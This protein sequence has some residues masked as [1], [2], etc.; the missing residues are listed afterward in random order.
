[1]LRIL[2]IFRIHQP[3]K[4]LI[5]IRII[6]MNISL[7]FSDFL[8]KKRIFI[9][10]FFHFCLCLNSLNHSDKRKF[11]YFSFFLSSDLSFDS[12][13]AKSSFSSFWLIFIPLNPWVR[14]FLRIQ[15]ASNVAD[16]KHCKIG[17]QFLYKA[18]VVLSRCLGLDAEE[19]MIVVQH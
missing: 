14:I 10:F 16:P 8:I 19:I 3:K 5:R 18:C 15:E 17:E 4:K 9:L 12:L 1:M 7:R 2:F 6:V 11:Y 13:R